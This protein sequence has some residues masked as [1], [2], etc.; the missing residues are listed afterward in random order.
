MRR[1]QLLLLVVAATTSGSGC[2]GPPPELPSFDTASSGGAV[3]ASTGLSSA[4]QASDNATEGD[5]HGTS[6]SATDPVG[7]SAPDGTGSESSSADAGPRCG[8]GVLDPGELCDDANDDETDSCTT[9][10]LPAACDDSLQSGDETGL[11]CGGLCTPCVTCTT[12]RNCGDTRVCDAS[13]CRLPRSCAELHRAH[14]PLPYLERELLP[15][16]GGTS[17][18]ALCVEDERGGAAW[19]EVFSLDPAAGVHPKWEISGRGIGGVDAMQCGDLGWV[20]GLFGNGGIAQIPV[21]LAQVPHEEVRVLG[22][23]LIAD[24]WDSE[25]IALDVDSE[26]VWSEVCQQGQGTCSLNDSNHCGIGGNDGLLSFDGRTAHTQD[27]AVLR[28]HA[29]INSFANDESWGAGVF[30]VLVR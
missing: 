14:A 26:L 8:D 27:T 5:T 19:T 25:Q 16:A 23:V 2:L 30:R 4:S 21:P 22:D 6:G 1:A 13:N 24:T 18:E 9:L 10:C 12:H 28:F 20:L 7:T 17:F 15:V 3:G 11:D 29:N